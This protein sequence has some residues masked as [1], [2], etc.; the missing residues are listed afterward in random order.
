MTQRAGREIAVKKWRA[1][2]CADSREMRGDIVGLWW[3]KTK[4][5]SRVIHENRLWPGCGPWRG[6]N[7]IVRC[8]DETMS[9]RD[10]TFVFPPDFSWCLPMCAS[11]LRQR[12]Q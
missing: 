7:G 10:I 3:R 5:K 1:L 8:V 4:K 6:T 12:E 11:L 2:R 9:Y